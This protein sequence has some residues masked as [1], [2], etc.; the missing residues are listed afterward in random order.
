MSIEKA[1]EFIEKFFSDDAF[2]EK[3]IREGGLYKRGNDAPND[4]AT[5]VEAAKAVGFDFTKEEF[6]QANKTYKEKVGE[7]KAIKNVFHMIK[8]VKKVR[9][10]AN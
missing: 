5:M 3:T 7:W 10:T 6:E 9:K 2:M 1:N 4:N 8:I